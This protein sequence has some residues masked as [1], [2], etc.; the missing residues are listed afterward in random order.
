MPVSEAQKVL[1]WANGKLPAGERPPWAV[2]DYFK[3][4]ETLETIVAGLEAAAQETGTLPSAEPMASDKPA[5][6]A[7]PAEN[8]DPADPLSGS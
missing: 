7:L 1:D 2:L 4:R 8:A 3:L 5:S 6:T